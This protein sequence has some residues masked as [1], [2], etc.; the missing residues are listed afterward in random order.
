M[1]IVK[2]HI[3]LQLH[4]LDKVVL[5]KLKLMLHKVVVLVMVIVFK[6]HV[7]HINVIKDF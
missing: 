7:I 1:L 4:N 5:V 6:L 3:L 2:K